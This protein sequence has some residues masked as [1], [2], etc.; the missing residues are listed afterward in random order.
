[1]FFPDVRTESQIKSQWD[2]YTP[3]TSVTE[4]FTSA[5]AEGRN[6]SIGGKLEQIG[7]LEDAR[8]RSPNLIS[9]DEANRIL[10]DIVTPFTEDVTQS[11]SLHE[12]HYP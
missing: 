11:N 8:K 3:E 12:V 1:M 6:M 10:P 9:A 7:Q 4:V 5:F 2:A